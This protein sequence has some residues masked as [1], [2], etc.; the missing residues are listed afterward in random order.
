MMKPEFTASIVKPSKDAHPYA[1]KPCIPPPQNAVSMGCTVPY[2]LCPDCKP[3]PSLWRRLV[4]ALKDLLLLTILTGCNYEA[5]Q[6][7]ARRQEL[8][9]IYN[10]PCRDEA[11]LLATTAGSPNSLTCP[12]RQH[13][14]RVEIKTSPSNEEIGALVFCECQR[15][16]GGP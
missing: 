2:E 12:N 3:K 13:R 16:D 8:D 11:S 14:M 5:K 10:G 4:N 6:E 9:R 15:P 7:E 1:P